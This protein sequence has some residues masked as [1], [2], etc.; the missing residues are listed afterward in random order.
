M[1][2]YINY[3]CYS[4]ESLSSKVSIHFALVKNKTQ[5]IKCTHIVLKRNTDWLT[6]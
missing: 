6:N 3:N 1:L 5:E 2:W 4:Y